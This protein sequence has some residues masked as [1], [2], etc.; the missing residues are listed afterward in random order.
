M[1]CV[2]IAD[3]SVA[4]RVHIRVASRRE[5]LNKWV[6]NYYKIIDL[7]VNNK[8]IHCGLNSPHP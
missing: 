3:N 1:I 2:S 7:I 6:L 5:R 4:L 8:L